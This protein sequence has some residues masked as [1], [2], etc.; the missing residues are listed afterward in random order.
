MAFDE[1]LA[2]RIRELLG[3]RSDVSEKRMF[4]GIAFLVNGNMS[5]GVTKDALMVRVG[6]DAYA[7]VLDHPHT[8]EMDFTGR[9]LTGFV[10]VDEAGISEDEHLATWVDRGVTF[11]SSLPPK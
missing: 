8:R 3:G 1:G 2:E 7:E 6:P 11:A 4:G 9:P 5:V 10:Y